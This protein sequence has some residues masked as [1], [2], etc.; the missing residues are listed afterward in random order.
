MKRHS[1]GPARAGMLFRA[2]F[3]CICL[4]LFFAQA[5]TAE[6]RAPSPGSILRDSGSQ[7]NEGHVN[8]DAEIDIP[9]K[10]VS[11]HFEDVDIRVFIRFISKAANK[12]FIVDRSVKGNVTIISPRE[13]SSKEAYRVFESVLEVH[14]FTTVESGS[15]TKIVPLP[16]ARSKNI[17][18]RLKKESGTPSDKIVTQIIPLKYAN[19]NVMKT[20]FAQLVSKNSVILSY[21]PT[22]ILI[23]TDTASN[24]QRLMEIVDA[25]DIMSIGQELSIIPLRHADATSFSRMLAAVFMGGGQGAPPGGSGRMVKFIPDE[26]T[27]ALIIM[28]GKEDAGR[29]RKLI[30]I[31]D[32]E[33]PRGEGKIH[34][35]PLENASAED[36]EK[37]LKN[38]SSKKSSSQPGK[39][40]P[41][42]SGSVTVASDKSTNSLVITA[43][44]DDYQVLEKVIKQLDIPRTM[45]YIECLIMEVNIKKNFKIGV[46]WMAGHQDSRMV[47][48]FLPEDGVGDS[49]LAGVAAGAPQG[50]FSIGALF[51]KIEVEGVEFP[52][53][54]AMLNAH[55]KDEGIHVLST[56][57]ILTLNNEEAKITVGKNVAF[58]TQSSASTS[59]TDVLQSY[60]YKD[61]GIMLKITPQIS[62]GRMVRLKISQEVT[63]VEGVQGASRTPTTTKRSIDTSVIVKDKNTVVIGG[64][65]DHQINRIDY[66]APC[67]GD[68]PLFGYLFK[69][70][71]TSNDKSNL[72]IFLTP[73]VIGRPEE[74]GEMYHEKKG[75]L[76]KIKEGSIKMY[77]SPESDLI[78]KEKKKA[79][80]WMEKD[81]TNMPDA[82]QNT[83]K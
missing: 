49:A 25:V 67:L 5:A 73:Y 53:L 24:I 77:E 59:A 39:R 38:I 35:R 14:G 36:I 11:I 79:M 30:A 4:S 69:T 1:I 50:G 75:Y 55:K 16:T 82:G 80:D 51:D 68:L 58:Q 64:L 37:V 18:T 42:I 22:N 54:G 19:P 2:G 21:L 7:G 61:V 3:I 41:L 65:I 56:P 40:S 47:G 6:T 71:G 83:E 10:T 29:I 27:N 9:E 17:E 15:V 70:A 66:R 13:I 76:E 62:K 20:L 26:R 63:Q 31:L 46:D 23:I 57:Q 8:L 43:D 12:N 81:S 78:E 28:A 52:N 74:A 45:V 60:E 34:V 72:F 44:K 48:G 33:T 32:V